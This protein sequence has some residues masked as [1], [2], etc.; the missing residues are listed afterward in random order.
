[1]VTCHNSHESC[2]RIVN[3]A[4]V[5]QRPLSL[6]EPMVPLGEIF[7]PKM[8]IS[9][10]GKT[11]AVMR[12]RDTTNNCKYGE[13]FPTPDDRKVGPTLKISNLVLSPLFQIS[14]HFNGSQSDQSY[15]KDYL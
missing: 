1:M 11:L 12:L 2:S 8:E 4:V 5:K 13:M 3:V 7:A 15:V 14:R 6:S 10:F 9:V